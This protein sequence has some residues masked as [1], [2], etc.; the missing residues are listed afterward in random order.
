MV[1]TLPPRTLWIV[2][3]LAGRLTGVTI[4]SVI[5]ARSTA[6]TIEQILGEEEDGGEVEEEKDEEVA[7]T[8]EVADPPAPEPLPQDELVLA[9]DLEARIEVDTITDG[10]ERLARIFGAMRPADAARVL[11]KLTETEVRAILRHIPDRKAAEILG[12]LDPTRAAEVS[13]SLIL[14]GTK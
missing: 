1:N 2:L 3:A 12:N 5:M 13:R 14:Q 8:E 6:T 4:E 10:S 11:E 7:E 9:P